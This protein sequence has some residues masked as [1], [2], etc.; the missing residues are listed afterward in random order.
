MSIS[1]SSSLNNC[2]VVSSSSL[3][4]N[5]KHAD[6]TNLLHEWDLYY[7]STTDMDWSLS[8]YEKIHRISSF[9]EMISLTESIPENMIKYGMLFLM[10]QGIL[11]VYEDVR[12][13]DGGYFS[14]KIYN[15]YVGTLWKQIVY[16]LCGHTIMKEKK[17]MNHVNGI[18]ISPKRNFCILKVWLENANNLDPESIIDIPNLL[19]VGV[20]FTLFA[21]K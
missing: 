11:P 8:K 5:E 1:S 13:K 18:S 6:D 2:A 16:A 9:Y 3:N 20:K 14:F 15:K 12:N 7:H 17:H 21:D 19:K 4:N 10:K